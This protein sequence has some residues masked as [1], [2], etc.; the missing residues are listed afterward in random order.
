MTESGLCGGVMT[1]RSF[2]LQLVLRVLLITSAFV[3]GFGVLDA[4]AQQPPAQPSPV[5]PPSA[6]PK[7]ADPKPSG[8]LLER[9]VS[10]FFNGSQDIPDSP[11]PYTSGP[12]AELRKLPAPQNSPPFPYGEYQIG[13]TPTIGDRNEQTAYPL[14]KALFDGPDGQWWKDSRVFITGWVELGAN[15][16]T[17]Q[18]Q[19]GSG[20]YGNAPY[21]YEQIPNSINLHQADIHAI[22]AARHLSDR[23][24]RLG[25]S[26]R[27]SLRARLPLHDHEGACSATSC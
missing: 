6:A 18:N 20:N 27:R 17:S 25:L 21:L 7:P 13:G 11:W 26:R 9:F 24:H 15:L 14:M 22:S 12:S 8:G 3:I 1:L 23:S 19:P 4:S 5:Q 10:N 16:S 2:I